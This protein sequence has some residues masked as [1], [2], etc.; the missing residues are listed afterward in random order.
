MGPTPPTPPHPTSRQRQGEIDEALLDM[1][2]S[3]SD[4][5]TF[6]QAILD[7]RKVA[8]HTLHHTPSTTHT[9]HHTHHHTPST[10]HS[11]P[12]TLHHTHSPPHTLH[13]THHQSSWL[14]SAM[15]HF[16]GEGGAGGGPD[17][18]RIVPHN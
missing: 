16:A 1:L 3:F 8:T 10:T 2:L 14:Y 15:F 11:P 6:K 7:Y 4:F 17:G 13:H 9:L 18:L 12:H 5:A